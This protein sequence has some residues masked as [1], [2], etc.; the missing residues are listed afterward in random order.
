MGYLKFREGDMQAARKWYGE[1]VKL[2]SQSYLA[3]YYYAAMSMQSSG[4]GS[5]SR[6]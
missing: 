4:A 6:D 3:H 5:G 1:A 2:D